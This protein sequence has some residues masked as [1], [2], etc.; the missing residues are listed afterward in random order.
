LDVIDAARGAIAGDLFSLV[1][2][3]KEHEIRSGGKWG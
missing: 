2:T 1:M 3:G